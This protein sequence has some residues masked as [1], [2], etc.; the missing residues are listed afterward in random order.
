[1]I[2]G[3]GNRGEHGPHGA[4]SEWLTLWLGDKEFKI[5]KIKSRKPYWQRK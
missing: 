3:F 1:M 4:Y 2:M 5:W